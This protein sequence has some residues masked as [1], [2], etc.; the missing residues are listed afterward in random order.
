MKGSCSV[1][2]SRFFGRFS[3]GGMSEP[4][5][6]WNGNKGKKLLAGEERGKGKRMGKLW[7]SWKVYPAGFGQLLRP[8]QSQFY[9]TEGAI[10]GHDYDR[11]AR[12]WRH[13]PALSYGQVYV[14]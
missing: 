10:Y 4:H 5:K 12:G 14:S 7:E 3:G 1:L 9:V 6:P 13:N 11:H 2:V 8:G